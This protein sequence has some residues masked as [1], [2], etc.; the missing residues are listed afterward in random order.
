M[1]LN[2][3]NISVCANQQNQLDLAQSQEVSKY[4]SQKQVSTIT[5]NHNIIHKC[6]TER[7]VGKLKMKH[8][9]ADCQAAQTK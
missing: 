7:H 8:S 2:K 4:V 3:E 9:W 5:N 1:F 6:N